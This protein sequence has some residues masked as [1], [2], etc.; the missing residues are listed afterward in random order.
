MCR[1]DRVMKRHCGVDDSLAGCVLALRPAF[2]DVFPG[3]FRDL[4]CEL[5]VD[6]PEVRDYCQDTAVDRE[7]GD[8]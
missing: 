6:S 4:Q 1:P 5:I 7:Y 3:D 2:E 8:S